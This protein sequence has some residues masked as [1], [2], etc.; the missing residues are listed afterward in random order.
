MA[1]AMI[2]DGMAAAHDFLREIRMAQ[3][4]FADAKK[5]GARAVA[6]ELRQHLR[7]DIGVGSI[8]DGDGHRR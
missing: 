8:V 1:L 3:H 4:A 5:R 2:F 6:L 7:R